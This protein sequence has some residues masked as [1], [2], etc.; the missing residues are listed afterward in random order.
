MTKP[1]QVA[2][3]I[4]F[5]LL[6]SAASVSAD[7]AYF[8]AL[9]DLPGGARESSARSISADGWVVVGYGTTA[10]GRR[11]FRWT[12]DDGMV[13]LTAPVPITRSSANGVSGNGEVIVG[14][15]TADSQSIA[16]RWTEA[17][18]VVLLDSNS[19]V[20][21]F[22]S[23]AEGVSNDGST[24]IGK[25][26]INSERKT[27]IWGPD[28][29][30]T[31]IDIPNGF[32]TYL[33]CISGNG[34][35]AA[36]GTALVG[37]P[38]ERAFCWTQETGPVNLGYL[39]STHVDFSPLGMS[40]NGTTIVGT[41]YHPDFH[42]FRWN[43]ETGLAYLDES[44]PG[45]EETF[46][47]DVTADGSV[48]VGNCDIYNAVI[49]GP[50][51]TPQKITDILMNDFSV[52]ISTWELYQALGVSDDGSKIVG[53]GRSPSH[54][55]EAWLARIPASACGCPGDVNSDG[56]VDG[57]DVRKF[58]DCLVGTESDCLC[59]NTDGLA[60]VDTNDIAYFASTMLAGSN[61]P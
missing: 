27:V 55:N 3:A 51:G 60:G 15:V 4:T 21:T 57:N 8:V 56:A 44:L 52:N 22:R 61:F 38:G 23:A 19:S 31:V 29:E 11:A 35:T 2:C 33:S 34:K 7:S 36:L 46:A 40:A 18:G 54:Y 37:T 13:E 20:G 16:F 5:S 32:N 48:I 53:W 39:T 58:I 28:G 14:T 25:M 41:S 49:W 30:V 43:A 26:A 10:A 17:D 6:T 50:D 9:G 24:I 1:L 59:A 45:C 47:T 42:A 12:F